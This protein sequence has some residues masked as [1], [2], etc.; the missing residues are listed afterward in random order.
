MIDLLEGAAGEARL[1]LDQVLEVGL[2]GYL[3]SAPDGLM[4]MQ[5]RTGPHGVDSRETS[6]VAGKDATEGEDE[7]GRR[8]QRPVRTCFGIFGI[9]PQRVV[10]A[11]AVCVVTDV[12][13]RRLI[14]PRL[15]GVGDRDTDGPPKQ[16]HTLVGDG[17]ESLLT[18]T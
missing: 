15:D 14:T 18:V 6:D 10:V 1:M 12:V 9:T 5:I 8:N 17:G 13:P 4:P 16:L 11:D 7:A 3:G 2:R